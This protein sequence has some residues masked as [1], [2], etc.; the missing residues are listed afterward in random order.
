MCECVNESCY[1]PPSPVFLLTLSLGKQVEGHENN[2]NYVSLHA[3]WRV[4][5]YLAALAFLVSGGDGGGGGGADA[6]RRGGEEEEVG[7]LAN[8]KNI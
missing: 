8:F 7:L 2:T 4:L 3:L 5:M 1:G 6:Q